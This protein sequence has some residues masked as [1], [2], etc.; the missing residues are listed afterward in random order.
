MLPSIFSTAGWLGLL[1]SL[2][3]LWRNWRNSALRYVFLWAFLAAIVNV[4]TA[5]VGTFAMVPLPGRYLALL[6]ALTVPVAVFGAREPGTTAWNFVVVGFLAVGLLPVLQQPWHSPEW[7]LDGLYSTLMATILV[8]GWLNYL[9]TR[10]G[11]AASALAWAL[12][13]QLAALCVIEPRPQLL[14]LAD[15][16]TSI[17]VLLA[18]LMTLLQLRLARKPGS[19][20]IVPLPDGIGSLSFDKQPDAIPAVQ[21]FNSTWRGLRDGWGLVWAWRIRELVESSARH[22]QLPG[23]FR[24]SGLHLELPTKA[25]MVG[26]PNADQATTVSP[27]NADAIAEQWYRLLQ[28]VAR[29]FAP[30]V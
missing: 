12:G 17:G 13:W 1:S 14:T 19:A 28:A 29:R 6:F 8:G 5:L 24:W 16:C 3:Y 15:G 21:R 20:D 26:Q 30:P 23:E 7:R 4:T 11:I 27:M 2:I 18:A 9:P 22:A 10:S 25:A